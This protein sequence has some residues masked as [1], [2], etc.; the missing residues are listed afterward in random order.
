MEARVA[1]L[2]IIPVNTAEDLDRFVELPWSI[3]TPDSLWVPNLKKQDRELL[4]PGE[5]PFWKTARRELFLALRDGRPVHL[6]G[7]GWFR[8]TCQATGKGVDT[9]E[10]VNAQQITGVRVQFTPE[11]ERNMGGGYTRALVDDLSFTKWKGDDADLMPDDDED[12]SGQGS[13]EGTLG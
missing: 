1:E 9:E 7:F 3:Y 8:F 10:E 6:E 4:S 11:R 5:H 12:D 2:S 13:G